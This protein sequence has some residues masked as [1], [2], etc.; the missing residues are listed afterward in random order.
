M[1]ATCGGGGCRVRRAMKGRGAKKEGG[2]R[3]F[4]K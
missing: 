1:G 2:G 4:K 3:G